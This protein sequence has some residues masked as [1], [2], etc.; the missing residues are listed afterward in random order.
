MDGK[1]NLADMR[2]NY[3]SAPFDKAHV[4][5]NPIAQFKVWFDEAV[6]S[7]IEEPN[8][9]TLA[10]ASN[11]GMPN[12]RIVL[13]K[14]FDKKGFV[15]YTNYESQKGKEL[16]NNNA[17]VLLFFWKELVR[18][19]RINGNVE[20]ISHEE[21]NEYFHSRPRESQIGAWT[22]NQ[23]S[24]IPDRNFLENRFQTLQNE[25]DGKEIPLPPYWGGYRVLP[26]EIEFWQGRENR[27]HDRILYSLIENDW[28]ISRLSP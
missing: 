8:A 5:K 7:K 14:E 3:T 23:S 27:L 25:F 11:E 17:A 21:S 24:E 28:K 18:Q 4:L 6:L 16:E 12:A 15:F 2:T 19:V 26:F 20:K 1:I 22:S 9:M 10:T 13:L